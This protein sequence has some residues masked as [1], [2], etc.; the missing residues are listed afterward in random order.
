MRRTL[1]G[2]WRPN[3]LRL[4]RRER[5]ERSAPASSYTEMRLFPLNMDCSL[6]SRD[7]ALLHNTFEE[8]ART[9]TS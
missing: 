2:A 4:S 8:Q 5:S 6:A 3:D 9:R 7:I 1:A